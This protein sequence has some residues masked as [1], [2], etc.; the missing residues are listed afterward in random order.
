MALVQ[1]VTQGL[2][3]FSDLGLRGSV[4]QD[5]RGDDPDFLNTA[6][7]MQIIRSGVIFLIVLA[8]AWPVAI[9]YEAPE[10]RWLLPVVG[11]GTL[12]GGFQSTAAISLVR[13]VQPAR[14]IL[15]ETGTQIISIIVMVIWAAAYPSV[16]ALVAGGL[17]AAIVRTVISHRLIP[18]YTNRLYVDRSAFH[19]MFHFGKWIFVS[20]A[21]SFI[22]MKGDRLV[23]GKMLTTEE[24]GVCS[25]ALF[26]SISTIGA[27][28]ALSRTI[29]FPVY[30]RLKDRGIV[31]LRRQ[32]F[33]MRLALTGGMF[34]I[35]VG[36]V[37][38]GEPLVALL[39][40]DR[41]RE[42]GWMLEILSI[43]MIGSLVTVSA[44]GILLGMG[45][46]FR[47]MQLQL[48]RSLLLVAG[49]AIGGVLGGLRGLLV[50]MTIARF[51]EY[52]ALVVLIRRYGVW[53][54]WLDLATFLGA[55]VTLAVGLLIG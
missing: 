4:I 1:V 34:P 3:M 22:L 18:G 49:M 35:L 24:L 43:G 48:A 51:L 42:A 46:S 9:F 14:Q 5:E 41:Y 53:L 19:S 54:P 26:L 47:H 52:P 11:L 13:K 33:R 31:E 6:W 8:L 36:L 20:T 28:T 44:N 23:L 27:V 12:V 29:L 39:Y 37:L 21:L 25:I 10:L 2:R 30:S 40:D 7:T 38:F 45:D 50:G 32:T 55:G 16:W 17:V 15:L